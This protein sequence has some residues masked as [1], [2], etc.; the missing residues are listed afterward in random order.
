MRV[1]L[2]IFA[3][4]VTAGAQTPNWKL[5]K[6]MSGEAVGVKIETYAAQIAR[7]GDIVKV[8]VDFRL[9]NGLPSNICD[10]GGCTIPRGV[11]TSEI[12]GMTARVI[13]NCSN[14][15]VTAEKGKGEIYMSNGKHYPSKEPPFSLK[16]GHIF[17]GYFC[18][19]ASA[20]PTT[21][22]KLKP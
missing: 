11:D 9:A 7:D 6:E 13:L 8:S 22:P 5:I 2:I 17:P 19:Q 20:A 10:D 14:S 12:R 16:N 3:L 1:L 21:A 4:S 18:E 15:T